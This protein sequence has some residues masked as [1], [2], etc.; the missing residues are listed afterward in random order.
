MVRLR[1]LAY[2]SY[3]RVQVL[4]VRGPRGSVV[5]V[6]CKGKGCPK[7]TRRKRPKG[8]SV[9]F[10]TFERKIRVGSSLQVFVVAKGPDRQVLELQDAPRQGSA[11]RRPL[12]RAGQEEAAALP[13]AEASICT[14]RAN[15]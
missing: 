13:V 14:S 15:R 8:H 3:T 5:K 9:R 1:G 7:G 11:A 4:S 12:P 10:K 6:R 2:R